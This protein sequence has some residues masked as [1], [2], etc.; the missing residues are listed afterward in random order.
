MIFGR[1]ISVLI[2]AFATL[3]SSVAFAQTRSTTMGVSA[4]VQTNCSVAATPMAFAGGIVTSSASVESAARIRVDCTAPVAF[5]VDM[6]RGEN[7]AGE[8]RRMVSENGDF[9]EYQIYSD[10]ALTREWGVFS[11]G[12][13]SDAGPTELELVA[14]GRINSV[15]LT[16]PSGGYQD[17]VTVTVSF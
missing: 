9:L 3:A 7:P 11:E 4:V 8:Q 5:T 6:D 16:T 15:D 17:T 10:A 12:V 13:T 14:Y 1:Y 2:T